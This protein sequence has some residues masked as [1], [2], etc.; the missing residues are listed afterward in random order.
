MNLYISDLH[1]G[2]NAVI[3]FE[4]RPFSGTDE[5]DTVLIQLWNSRVIL[6]FIM[7]SHIAG[8]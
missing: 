2:H 4:H 1:F 5:M 3:D 6:H 7:K 8:I